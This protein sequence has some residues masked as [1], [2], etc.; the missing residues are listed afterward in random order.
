MHLQHRNEQQL[1]LTLEKATS[2]SLA[3]RP[4]TSSERGRVFRER[5]RL[6]A[7]DLEAQVGHMR[8]DLKLLRS[9]L[10]VVKAKRVQT[11]QQEQHHHMQLYLHLPPPPSQ[12]QSR[13]TAPVKPASV[14]SCVA[15]VREL[16]AVLRYGLNK[17]DASPS[18]RHAEQLTGARADADRLLATRYKLGF[19]WRV[20]DPNVR[21]GNLVGIEAAIEQWQRHTAAYATLE[22]EL[23]S[24][25]TAAV[26]SVEH[27]EVALAVHSTLHVRSS[28]VSFASLFPGAL[29]Q[30]PELGASLLDR[31]MT[32]ECM[33]HIQFTESGLIKAYAQ[34]INVV[35]A[36]MAALGS[37]HDVADLLQYSA[38]SQYGTLLR[39][40]ERDGTSL[41]VHM[42]RRKRAST[43]QQ[44]EQEEKEAIAK[45]V[46]AG[47]HALH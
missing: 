15:L 21:F 46:L 34:E 24:I 45:R 1:Q 14:E 9:K 23:Q 10:Q 28:P 26:A 44:D 25:Q 19:L 40:S 38:M 11:Q 5:Q 32:F 47:F 29:K 42:T 22:M 8:R 35:K 30:R 39:E 27:E 3:A 6:R 12:Q 37:V 13:P 43:K 41:R 4:M 7:I 18:G 20:L 16:F 2:D 17:L 31:D 36:L 33:T